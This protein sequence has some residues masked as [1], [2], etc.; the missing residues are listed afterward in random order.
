M[1]KQLLLAAAISAGL[2]YAPATMAQATTMDKPVMKDD[3]MMMDKK[4]DGM[5][6]PAADKMKK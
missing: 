6:K 3:K 1:T 5:A 4:P 2:A